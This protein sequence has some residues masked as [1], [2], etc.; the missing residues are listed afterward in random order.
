MTQACCPA[1]HLRFSRATAVHLAACPFCGEPLERIAP[2][3]ALGF[4]LMA[5]DAEAGAIDALAVALD[6]TVPEGDSPLTR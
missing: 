4:K 6:A 5:I 1:C 2:L 3:D